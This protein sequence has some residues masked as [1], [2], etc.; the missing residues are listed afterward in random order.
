MNP[1]IFYEG[2][3]VSQHNVLLSDPNITRRAVRFS[4][5]TNTTESQKGLGWKGP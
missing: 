5:L 1:Y 4:G 2:D 3:P